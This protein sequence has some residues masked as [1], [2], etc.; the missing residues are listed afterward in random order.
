MHIFLK[1]IKSCNFRSVAFNTDKYTHRSLLS[2]LSSKVSNVL[3]PM[4]SKVNEI[5]PYFLQDENLDF[6]F[7]LL[8]DI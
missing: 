3:N 2:N 5:N 7:K 6:Y 1:R 8:D 4:Y